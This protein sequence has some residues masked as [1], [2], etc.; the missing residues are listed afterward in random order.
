MCKSG[1]LSETPL[2]NS[3]YTSLRGARHSA[4]LE[5]SQTVR[6]LPEEAERFLL[7]SMAT[8]DKLRCDG[9]SHEERPAA[10]VKLAVVCRGH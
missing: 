7:S 5:P 6:L 10:A 1:K 8:A 3:E 2:L 4:G 9:R